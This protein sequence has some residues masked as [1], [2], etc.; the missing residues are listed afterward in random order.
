MSIELVHND[1]ESWAVDWALVG[2]IVRSYAHSAAIFEHSTRVEEDTDWY[3]PTSWLDASMVTL[4]VDWDAVRATTT[5]LSESILQD[6]YVGVGHDAQAVRDQLEETIR[7]T[8][9][10][11]EAHRE[12]WT[13]ASRETAENIERSVEHLEAGAEVSKFIRDMSYD[14]VLIGATFMSGG[15]AAAFTI[16][17]GLAKGTAT[18]QDT[19]SVGAATIETVGSVTMNVI[20]IGGSVATGTSGVVAEQGA[21]LFLDATFETTKGL[22]SGKT[23]SEA[24]V[25]GGVKIVVGTATPAI[26]EHIAESQAV[27]GLIRRSALPA[28]LMLTGTATRSE[29]SKRFSS[30]VG[31]VGSKYMTSLPKTGGTV[32]AIYLGEETDAEGRREDMT[33]VAHADKCVGSQALCAQLDVLDYAI[34]PAVSLVP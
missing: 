8:I 20:P 33:R 6:F 25:D 5:E 11:E 27:Q 3:D 31:E 23:M 19:G 15:A 9:S 7:T 17:G 30:F 29:A 18:Y 24:V 1:H 26:S 12:G 16:G 13:A 28:K 2:S 34:Q 21:L 22:A 32:S 10:N 4:E 14:T